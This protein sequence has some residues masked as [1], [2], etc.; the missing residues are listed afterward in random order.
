MAQASHPRKRTARGRL[1]PVLLAVSL[2]GAMAC[3]RHGRQRLDEPPEVVAFQER[4][5]EFLELSKRLAQ[6]LPALEENTQPEAMAEH[7]KALAARLREARA[8]AK[9]GDVFTPEI[10]ARVR[11]IV[12]VN[13]QGT[14]GQSDKA[15]V[16]E[17]APPPSKVRLEVNADY[18][19]DKA[20]STMPPNL[21]FKLPELPEG[22]DYRFVGRHLIL[23]SM[24]ANIIVDYVEDA[25]HAL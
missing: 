21:L 3:S 20:L 17:D 16:R 7:R 23:R 25:A 14:L 1:G 15:A 8:G 24:D 5:R 22:V 6:D 13:F 12:R 19:E 10:A 18:P 2:A 4:V 9:P 11:E